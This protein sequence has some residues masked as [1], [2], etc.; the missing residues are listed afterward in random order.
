MP[1]STQTAPECTPAMRVSQLAHG[2]IV[3]SALSA[4][5]RLNLAETIG[6]ESISIDAL[7]S[8]TGTDPDA[9]NRLLR[10]LASLEIFVQTGDK[11]YA[12]NEASNSLRGD[13]AESQRGFVEFITDPFHFTYYADIV[14]TIR[15]GRPAPE[16]A[17]GKNIFELLAGDPVEQTRFDNAMTDLSKAGVHAVLEAYDFININH[18]VDVAGGHGKLLTAI[19]TQYPQLK[20]TLFDQPHV[21]AGAAAHI[22]DVGLESRCGTAG[23][24]FFKEVPQADAY[25]M[26]HIIHDWDDERASLILKNCRAGLAR[27][28]SGKL[29]LVEMILPETA[30]PHPSVFLDVEMLVLPG[31]RERTEQEYR[32]LLER[33]GFRLTRVIP[34][35][36]PWCILEAVPV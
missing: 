9:L 31:G 29:L 20:G 32:D 1:T 34:T 17:T 12:N 11:T 8:K 5:I 6:D 18:L 27:N 16:I 10:L 22:K 4:A 28:G 23:G 2:F 35:K 30:Q 33:T 19:L 26:K 3:S 21:A 13:K 14:P 15:T 7:A 36:S 25:I 24:D